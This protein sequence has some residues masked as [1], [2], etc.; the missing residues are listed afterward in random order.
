MTRLTARICLLSILTVLTAALPN[1]SGEA[2]SISTASPPARIVASCD[3]EGPYSQGEQQIQEGLRNNWVFG[4]KDMQFRAERNAGR[5]GTVQAI[6]TRGICSGAVQ[7]FYTRIKLKKD[8]YSGSACGCART[9][10]KRP[11]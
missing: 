6:Y 2:Q 9:G 11:C 10:W 7:L 4:K 3:F 8:R 5:P 1:S